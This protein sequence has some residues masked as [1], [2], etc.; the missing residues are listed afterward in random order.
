MNRLGQPPVV[1]KGLK[2]IM[3]ESDRAIQPPNSPVIPPVLNQLH[4]REE[5]VMAKKKDQ[6]F[7]ELNDA[8]SLKKSMNRYWAL[9]KRSCS[10]IFRGTGSLSL[11][12]LALY[13]LIINCLCYVGANSMWSNREALASRLYK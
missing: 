13:G 8:I 5:G 10:N 9:Y 2:I 12:I 3:T 7:A 11:H 1:T 4:K 6:L